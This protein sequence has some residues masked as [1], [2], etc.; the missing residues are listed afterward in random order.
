MHV[1]FYVWNGELNYITDN[2]PIVIVNRTLPEGLSIGG[3]NVLS[4]AVTDIAGDKHN[5]VPISGNER[6]F[7]TDFTEPPVE[8]LN[9]ITKSFGIVIRDGQAMVSSREVAR[10]FGRPH[11]SVIRSIYLTQC[12]D[13]F[14][15]KNFHESSY[16][17]ERNR[18]QPEY[19]MT[20][21]GFTFMVMGFT[22]HVAA[23]FKEAYIEAFNVM[24]KAL[25]GRQ[26]SV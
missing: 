15:C 4:Q 18:K 12:S 23:E 13:A 19:Y 20:R 7:C 11:K 26:D 9:E 6:K 22:G 5:F 16:Y 17:D 25:G 21:D 2:A 8:S 1:L 24:E 10:V 3:E 14:R